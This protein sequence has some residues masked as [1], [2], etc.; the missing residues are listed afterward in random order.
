[1]NREL[2]AETAW[3]GAKASGPVAITTASL[4]G[5]SLQDWV[6]ILTVVYTLMLIS[7]KAWQWWQH[8]RAE[9]KPKRRK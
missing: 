2:V 9:R 3:D 8:F 6:L 5:I 1:M 4:S 7:Q